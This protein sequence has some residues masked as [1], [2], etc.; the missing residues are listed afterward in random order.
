MLW[1]FA[2]ICR[3]TIL[4]HFMTDRHTQ[5][6]FSVILSILV[7]WLSWTVRERWVHGSLKLARA[8]YNNRRDA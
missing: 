3:N 8:W 5:R 1:R 4:Q 7:G 2:S 6:P